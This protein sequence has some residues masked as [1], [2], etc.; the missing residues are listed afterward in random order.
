MKINL[1]GNTTALT[2]ALPIKKKGFFQRKKQNIKK[3]FLE[4]IIKG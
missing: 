4:K 3:E 1:V 2:F